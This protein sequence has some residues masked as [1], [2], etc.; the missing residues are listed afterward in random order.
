MYWQDD[1]KS[2]GSVFLDPNEWS[3]DGTIALKG[4][5]FSEDGSLLAYGKSSSG[6]DWLDIHV[7]TSLYF[8]EFF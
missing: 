5:A 8:I 1:L 6:S 4:K 7:Q 3:E 2:E